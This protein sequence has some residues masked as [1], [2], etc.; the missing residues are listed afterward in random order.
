MLGYNSKMSLDEINGITHC[1]QI[2][3]SDKLRDTMFNNAAPKLYLM[4]RYFY[5][6]HLPS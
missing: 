4:L 6:I 2:S 5:P 1:A 3:K